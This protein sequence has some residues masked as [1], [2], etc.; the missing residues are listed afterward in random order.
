M[1]LVA[2]SIGEF[3]FLELGGFPAPLK[4]RISVLTRAGVDG[5]TL[6][7]DGVRGEEFILRSKVDHEDMEAALEAYLAHAAEIGSL[8]DIVYQDQLLNDGDHK[9]VILDVTIAVL[10][11]LGGAV[12][13]LHDP[14]YAWLECDWRLIAARAT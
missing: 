1:A 13:G 8:V 11:A 12:G 10:H 2:N 6:L 14:S 9:F 3:E 7:A 4:E 5:V